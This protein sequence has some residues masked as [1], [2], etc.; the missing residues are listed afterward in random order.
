MYWE[1]KLNKQQHLGVLVDDGPG[2]LLSCHSSGA[3]RAACWISFDLFMEHAM[4]GKQ[5]HAISAIETLTGAC[6]LAVFMVFLFME[7]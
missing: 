5:L 4:D 7:F 2:S 1:F 3:G 6:C